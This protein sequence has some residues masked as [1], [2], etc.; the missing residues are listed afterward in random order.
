MVPTTQL[1]CRN[2][3]KKTHFIST[4]FLPR[5]LNIPVNRRTGQSLSEEQVLGELS[6]RISFMLSR[7]V[8]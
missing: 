5:A 1:L 8:P 7:L 3:K 4:P 6:L 2:K